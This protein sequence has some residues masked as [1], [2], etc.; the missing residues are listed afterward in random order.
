[1]FNRRQALKLLFAAGAAA[2]LTGLYTWRWEPHWLEFTYPTLPIRG[3]PKELEGKTLAQIADTHIGP[4]V[5]DDYVIESFQQT[6]AQSPDFVVFTGDWISYRSVQQ[7]EQLKRVLA[8]V[9]HGRLGTI[10]IL[11]NHDY[12][13]AWSMPDVADSVSQI[14]RDAGVTVLR[15]DAVTV[16][17]LRFI[18]LDDFWGLNFHPG[19]A[20]AKYGNLR[21]SSSTNQEDQQGAKTDAK[22]PAASIVLSHNPDV[23]DLQ[24][25]SNYQGWILSGHTHGGQ[26][27]PPFLPPP[28]LPVKNKLYTAGKFNLPCN[29]RMYISRGVGHLLRVRFNVRPEIPVFTLQREV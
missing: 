14:A 1:M 9:P 18:G 2:A 17:G 12:G 24:V 3:L 4:E 6:Q 11:G 7:F 5:D 19:P 26:C 16:A 10:G 13:R 28:E 27:K 21:T 25:W 20:L 22:E 23:A 15:N 29:R 8:H